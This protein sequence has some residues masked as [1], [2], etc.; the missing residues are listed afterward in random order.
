VHGG[1]IVGIPLIVRRR[2]V[3]VNTPFGRSVKSL[4]FIEAD[5]VWVKAKLEQ[6]HLQA[7]PGNGMELKA[8]PSPHQAQPTPPGP[9]WGETDTDDAAGDGQ[10]DED[11]GVVIPAI[12]SAEAIRI[13]VGG[14]VG[15]RSKR[16]VLP[17]P[18]QIGLACAMIEAC[19][20]AG[21]DLRKEMR[22]RVFKFLFGVASSKEMTFHH[23][24]IL[25]WLKP[26]RGVDGKYHPSEEGAR[27]VNAV[28][29]AALMV[30]GQMELP[31]LDS[32]VVPE[33]ETIPF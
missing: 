4:V 21:A 13:K 26:T 8:L 1:R 17:N 25:D 6:M 24:A 33:Q 18:Q 20:N 3:E 10:D 29:H 15:E 19:F 16:G 9:G 2:P 5:S 11:Q 30:D 7:L 27:E 14:F 31:A 23:L 28:E 22:H 12:L 32:A